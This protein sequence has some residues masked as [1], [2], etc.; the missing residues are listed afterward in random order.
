MSAL[1]LAPYNLG[2]LNANQIVKVKNQ[3]NEK[4]SNEIE[5]WFFEKIN[6]IDQLQAR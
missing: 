3:P 6:E 2:K 4:K 5:I 1:K